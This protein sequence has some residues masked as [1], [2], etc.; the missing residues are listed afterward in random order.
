MAKSSVIKNSQTKFDAFA[1]FVA[2]S[3]EANPAQ[4]FLVAVFL[5]VLSVAATTWLLV[6]AFDRV[7]PQDPS[8]SVDA[9]KDEDTDVV[10]GQEKVSN[11]GDP[12]KKN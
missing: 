8:I 1:G 11:P 7:I 5:F 4:S 6:G 3:F 9:V 10:S 2:A 12:S